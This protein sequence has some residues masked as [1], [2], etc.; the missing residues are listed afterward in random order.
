VLQHILD[1][2]FKLDSRVEIVK[3]DPFE[4]PITAR[5]DGEN[6]VVGHQVA[7]NILVSTDLTSGEPSDE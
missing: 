2:G 6:R 1:R 4:G 3:R 7:E 5:V